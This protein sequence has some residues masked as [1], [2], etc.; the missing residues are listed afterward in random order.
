MIFSENRLPLF[1][2]MLWLTLRRKR[3]MSASTHR[4]QTNA[5]LHEAEVMEL[6]AEQDQKTNL[7]VGA[8]GRN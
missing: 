5:A 7:G 3:I 4:K 8:Q 2:I 1:Q 6:R